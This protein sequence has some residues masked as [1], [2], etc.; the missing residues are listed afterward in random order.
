MLFYLPHAE[1]MRDGLLLLGNLVLHLGNLLFYL[2]KRSR[3]ARFHH[4]SGQPIRRTIQQHLPGAI[5][6]LNMR[7]FDSSCN[8]LDNVELAHMHAGRHSRR[9]AAGGT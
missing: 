6:L 2:F 1:T 4:L 9:G 3:S 7:H 5:N 8:F